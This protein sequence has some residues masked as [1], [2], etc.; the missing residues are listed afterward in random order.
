MAKVIK[1][2][3]GQENEKHD[4]GAGNHTASFLG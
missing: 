2:D 4:S 1:S 3:N